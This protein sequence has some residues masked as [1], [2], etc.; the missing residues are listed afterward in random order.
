MNSYTYKIH[1][2]NNE[3]IVDTMNSYL[4]RIQMSSGPAAAAG[5]QA[6]LAS[7]PAGHGGRRR[8]QAAGASLNEAACA[9]ARP[10]AVPAGGPWPPVVV[11]LLFCDRDCH[12]LGARFAAAA[13]E[14]RPPRPQLQ[15]GIANNLNFKRTEIWSA[16]QKLR[17]VCPPRMIMTLMH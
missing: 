5:R 8:R 7:G 4:P 17:I 12:G 9:R 3:F 11:V 16:R 2:I 1:I 6:P 13:R 15:P 10:A 14:P